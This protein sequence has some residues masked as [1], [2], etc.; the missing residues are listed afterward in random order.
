[1]ATP[2]LDVVSLWPG[3][4]DDV[5]ADVVA[6]VLGAGYEEVL[7]TRPCRCQRTRHG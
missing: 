4:P 6:G 2:R 7:R 5:V 1:M 3:S